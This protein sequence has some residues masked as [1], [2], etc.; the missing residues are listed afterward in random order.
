VLELS[1]EK[2]NRPHENRNRSIEISP[3]PESYVGGPRFIQRR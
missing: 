2:R 1:E 3:R